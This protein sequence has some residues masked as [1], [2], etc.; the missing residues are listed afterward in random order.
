VKQQTGRELTLQGPIRLGF[1]LQPTLTVQ[2]AAFANPPGF[3]RPQ[4][5]TLERLDLKL[6][7]LPLISHRVEIDKLVLVKPDILL[8]IDAKG[9]PNWQFT[10]A[11]G[12]APQSGS[13]GGREKTPTRI[14]RRSWRAP[15]R[16][17]RKELRGQRPVAGRQ[18]A[19]HRQCRLQRRAIHPDR[20]CRSADPAGDAG[21]W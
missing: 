2:G 16:T 9:R 12:A 1:S 19:C 18:P 17:R 5:A 7:L 20:R 4:M 6:A 10:P 3:S 8:E 14:S 15:H 11:P 13:G 21:D